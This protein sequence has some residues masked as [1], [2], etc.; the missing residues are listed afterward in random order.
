MDRVIEIR[1][2]GG[3]ATVKLESGEALRVPSAVYLD[4]PLHKNQPIDPEA[5]RAFV[6]KKAYPHALE[7]AMQYLALREHSQQEVRQRLL[8]ACYD[9]ATV[10]RV[11]DALDAHAL[12]SDARFA[13]QWTHSRSRKYGK[14]RIA[15]EL[16]MKGVSDQEVQEALEAIP[17]EEE[18]GH[19]LDQARKLC[20]KFQNDPTKIAQSLIRK[21]FHWSLAK[22]AAEE[23][24]KE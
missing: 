19:A 13:E 14:G 4:Q 24:A 16:R 6:Q 5:Y 11:M 1:R 10:A 17:P 18:Y 8:R 22:R 12:V 21:G 3:V 20:R 7:T 23:A 9:E 2:Q 15:R